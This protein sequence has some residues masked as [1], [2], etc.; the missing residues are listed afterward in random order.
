M[1]LSR[2]AWMVTVLV[3]IVAT[4]ILLLSGYQ[5][6]GA[7]VLAVGGCAAINLI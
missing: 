1:S 3:C 4:L 6:Y 5:G 7:V 2:I